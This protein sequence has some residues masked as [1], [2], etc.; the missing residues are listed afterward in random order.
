MH[1]CG[2]RGMQSSSSYVA[3]IRLS[4]TVPQLTGPT[5]N[6]CSI[7][8]PTSSFDESKI[9]DI[10]RTGL[11]R[12]EEWK[13]TGTAYAMEHATKPATIGFVLRSNPLALLAWI[14]EKFLDWTDQD[15]ST[16]TI[17]EFTTLYWLTKCTS[18]NLWS[19]R[20]VSP[21]LAFPS[22]PYF[23]H[24][25]HL[26]T[27]ASQS[28]MF[29]KPPPAPTSQSYG[30]GAKG[31]DHPDYYISKPFGYSYFPKELIPIPV[32]WAKTSGNLVWSR[33]HDEG[34]HFAALECPELLL[35]DVESF[36]GEVWKR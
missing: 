6:F 4:L 3:L 5:V 22:I 32:E 10:E 29:A 17:L 36:V 15:P 12:W 20:H 7:N 11:K 18:T 34:G 21:P 25:P 1:E 23:L 19:Y 28:P 35:E 31:H 27:Q 33:I 9:S 24:S 8:K 26:L 2:T 30:A 16:Q 14:G 13:T